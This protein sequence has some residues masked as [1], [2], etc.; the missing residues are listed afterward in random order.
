MKDRI[1]QNFGKPVLSFIIMRFFLYSNHFLYTIEEIKNDV[2]VKSKNRLFVQAQTQFI[3]LTLT[4]YKLRFS[5]K[6]I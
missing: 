4:S 5:K 1:Y 6:E 3:L 2:S